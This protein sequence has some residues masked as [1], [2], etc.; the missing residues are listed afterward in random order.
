MNAKDT[1]NLTGETNNQSNQI[2]LNDVTNVISTITSNNINI[3]GGNNNDSIDITSKKGGR[4][5]GSTKWATEIKD[6]LLKESI[7]KAAILFYLA[8][9]EAHKSVPKGT[10]EKKSNI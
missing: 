6:A 2:P 3:S 8:C 4:P 1:T 10:L 5:K 9:E 7:A